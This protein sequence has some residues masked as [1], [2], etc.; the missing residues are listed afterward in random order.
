MNRTKISAFAALGFALVSSGNAFASGEQADFQTCLAALQAET[1]EMGDAF[2][3]KSMRGASL[4][5][6]SFE[7]N[8]GEET[9]T[10]V[11]NVKRGAVIDLDW[12]VG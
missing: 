2:E 9:K 5:R 11:C 12:N 10:V 1:A 6:L 4:R 7:M 8:N 3:F